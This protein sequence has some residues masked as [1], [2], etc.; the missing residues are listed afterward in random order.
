MDIGSI[1]EKEGTRYATLQNGVEYVSKNKID[2]IRSEGKSKCVSI[3]E[4]IRNG[5]IRKIDPLEDS[6]LYRGA[7][8][9]KIED[10]AT[11]SEPSSRYAEIV[12]SPKT[13]GIYFI[14]VDQLRAQVFLAHGLIYPAVYDKTGFSVN[15]N[16]SYLQHPAELVLFETPQPINNNQ[17][18]LKVLL[19]EEEVCSSPKKDKRLGVGFPLPISRLLEIEVPHVEDIN[20]YLDGWVK[21]DVSVPRHLFKPML[22]TTEASGNDQ[23]HDPLQQNAELIPGVRESIA[24]FDSYMGMMAFLRNS[25]RYFSD[26]TGYYSDYPEDYF[27]ICE[28]LLNKTLIGRAENYKIAPL[29]LSLMDLEPP[30]TPIVETVLSLIRSSDSYIN[31][32]K[33]RNIAM[34]IYQCAGQNEILAQAFRLLFSGDYRTAIQMLRRKDIPI[35]AAILAGLFKFSGRQ[36]NDHRNVKQRLHD[37]WDNRRQANLFLASLGAYYGYTA[38]DA[39]ETCL[40]SVLPILQSLID[41]HP[42]IKFHLDTKFERQLIEALYHRAF[43]PKDP[44]RDCMSFFD[45]VISSSSPATQKVPRVLLKDFQYKVEDLVVLRYEVTHVGRIVQQLKSWKRDTVDEQSA[46]GKWLMSQIFFFADEYELSSRAGKHILRYRISKNKIIELIV[47]EKIAVN[48]RMLEV[49]LE[50]DTKENLR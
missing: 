7:G 45:S 13:D 25:D 19:S 14:P 28:L 49:A 36:S 30:N 11:I 42:A 33:G 35:E 20:R 17:L 18:L 12:I 24:K 47:S 9:K 8:E 5:L 26:R 2:C 22:K 34:E 41:E 40:Y 43:F 4:A 1:F 21:P 37:E 10:N 27:R 16:D 6:E 38:L 44:I 29:L 48:P 32:E 50:E 23:R 15:Y 31:K 3:R 39:R 46:V